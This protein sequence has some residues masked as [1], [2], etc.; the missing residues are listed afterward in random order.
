MPR[1]FRGNGGI[2]EVGLSLVQANWRRQASNTVLGRQRGLL[3]LGANYVTRIGLSEG[4]YIGAVCQ[5]L[6]QLNAPNC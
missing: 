3:K 1:G 5:F 4:L 2:R 6:W